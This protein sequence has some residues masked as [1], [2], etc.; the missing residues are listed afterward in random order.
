LQIACKY[1]DYGKIER[2]FQ[3]VVHGKRRRMEMPHGFLS[4][5]FL[6]EDAQNDGLLKDFSDEEIRALYTA[7]HYHHTRDDNK[8]EVEYKA[9]ASENLLENYRLF[10]GHEYKPGSFRYLRKRLFVNDPAATFKS[11][12]EETYCIYL[13]I[14]GIL[15][16][17][18]YAAS[19]HIKIEEPATER[20]TEKI[21]ERFGE[22]LRPAQRF[23]RDHRNE[24]IVVI[25]PTG[26][27]KTE[28]ALLWL[29][30]AKG[31]YT[32]PL[33]VSADAIYHRIYDTPSKETLSGY[34]FKEVGLLHSDS[35][36]E[37]LQNKEGKSDQESE[38]QSDT[39]T[40]AEYR[41]VRSLAYPLTITTVDQLFKFVFKALGTEIFAATLKYSRVII[42]EMQM[43]EPRILAL[44][45][46]GLKII[47]LMGGKF[48]I[49]TATLP[50][51]VRSK[52][53]QENIPFADEVFPSEERRHIVHLQ[54]EEFADSFDLDA[55]CEA[56][57]TQRVLV[58]CNTVRHAQELKRQLPYARLL[59][60]RFI[61][62]ERARLESDIQDFQDNRKNPHSTGIWIS[63][64]LVEASLDIDFDVLHTELCT[65]D[66]LLQRMGRCWRSR[67]Y[68]SSRP[69]IFV[70]DHGP[71][72]IYD[73]DIFNRSK[74]F[75]REYENRIFTE[76]EKLA[77]VNAV[78]DEKE[79]AKSKYYKEFQD[80]WNIIRDSPP[81]M[82]SRKEADEHFRNIQSI[83]VI[84]DSVYE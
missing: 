84:P 57:K 19:G 74:E 34:G 82:Y 9:Y 47:T 64:Q 54:S 69:N 44:L 28:G 30:D 17:A 11:I 83:H 59:H 40:L 41:S 38:I 29:D 63:T 52:L 16:K 26:S 25:A 13:L 53:K 66:S 36:S 31:F 68:T 62:K 77:Y 79:I 5:L 21:T 8:N 60:S 71:C 33:K 42:D 4:G 22:K 15:N 78:F 58:I 6:Y 61:K 7:I 46:Y 35:I 18:D 23:M 67:T 43:Y 72:G 32:L 45:I 37:Y 76:S 70:Y 10:T 49:I 24:N 80:S 56:A 55:I 14:K 1:H 65:A 39:R 48:A 20:L 2:I 27:G 50:D 51:F 3:E 73:K 75:L 81:T 12:D